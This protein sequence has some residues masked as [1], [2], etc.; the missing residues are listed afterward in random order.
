[1]YKWLERRIYINCIVLVVSV[2]VNLFVVNLFYVIDDGMIF[3][4]MDDLEIVKFLDKVEFFVE[5][6][7]IRILFF[8]LE[9]IL[10]VGV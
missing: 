6:V 1:M 10:S 9:R 4:R 5:V 8:Y 7:E 2:G 3:F